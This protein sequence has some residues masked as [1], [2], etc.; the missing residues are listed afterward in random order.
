MTSNIGFT[1]NSIGFN[2]SKKST[3]ELKET[4]NLAFLNR[5]DYIINFNSLNKEDINKI[6]NKEIKKIQEKYYDIK[7]NLEENIILELIEES[8]YKEFGARKIEKVIKNKIE[9]IIIDNIIEN[10]K[11]VK[12]DSIFSK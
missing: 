3:N 11:E 6:I 2:N 8:N 9:N 12:I 7:I 1:N 5:I 4:F 10:K